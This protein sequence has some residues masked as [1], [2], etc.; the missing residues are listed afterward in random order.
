MSH[1]LRT[2]LN[3]VMG[4][5][6]MMKE[7]MLGEINAEQERALDKVL[8]RAHDQ[9]PMISAILQAAQIETKGLGREDQPVNLGDLMD[10]IK[11]KCESAYSTPLALR[12]E[13]PADLPIVRTDREKLTHVLKSLVDNAVKFTPEGEVK[14]AV[15]CPDST[16]LQFK[17]SDTGIGIPLDAQVAIF[18]KF[19]QVDSSETRRYGGVGLGLYIVKSFT[20]ILGGEVSVQSSAGAGSTFIVTL[21]R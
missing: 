8:A 1:E 12:W 7:K 6:G 20:E 11:S 17:V 3:V 2:P 9:L 10:E 16:H 19:R 15:T 14:I 18:E 13:Y 21:P 4:Y 5:V